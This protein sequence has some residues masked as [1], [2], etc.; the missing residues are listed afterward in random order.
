MHKED[1]SGQEITE[2]TR[3]PLRIVIGVV[4]STAALVGWGSRL[5]S[6]TSAV[7]ANVTTLQIAQVQLAADITQ[8]KVDIALIKQKLGIPKDAHTLTE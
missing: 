7:A 5:E 1:K 4:I 8:I 6:S 3:V 2:E